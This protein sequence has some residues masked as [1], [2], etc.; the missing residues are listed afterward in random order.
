MGLP[1]KLHV[2]A[3]FGCALALSAATAATAD[4]SFHPTRTLALAE[5]ALTL[6][7]GCGDAVVPRGSAPDRVA[8]F[9]AA[10][11]MIDGSATGIV[12][13][14]IVL[15]G[16]TWLSLMWRRGMAMGAGRRRAPDGH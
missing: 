10:D 7:Q 2:V 13:I 5:S 8:R 12:N 9:D 15:L 11:R 1:N 4:P 3:F 14:A 16:L 6:C